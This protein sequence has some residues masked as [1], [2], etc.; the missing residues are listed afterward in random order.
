M[1]NK[2]SL[3]QIPPDTHFMIWLLDAM[4]PLTSDGSSIKSWQKN[5]L[6]CLQTWK[7]KSLEHMG[8][9][10]R[11]NILEGFVY[12]HMINLFSFWFYM[13]FVGLEHLNY[14]FIVAGCSSCISGSINLPRHWG[15][16]ARLSNP[17]LEQDLKSS[18][19]GNQLVFW[20]WGLNMLP[21]ES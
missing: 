3:H 19:Q 21:F 9:A 17:F 11:K 15:P 5:D 20:G 6:K 12:L 2:L 7:K 8:I 10:Y 18:E 14:I 1:Q 4:H 13:L 16:I